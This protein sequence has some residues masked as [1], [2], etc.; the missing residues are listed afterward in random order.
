MKHIF[1][2]T[3]IGAALIAAARILAAP[4]DP[5]TWVEGVGMVVTAY[6]ARS[7]IAKNGTGE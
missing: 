3:V 4:R 6:G 7:A 1:S 2:R 5:M